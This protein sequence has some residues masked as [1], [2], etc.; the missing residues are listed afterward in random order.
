MEKIPEELT[1]GERYEVVYKIPG[2]HQFARYSIMDYLGWDEYT[3]S[4]WNAR[5]VAGTQSLQPEHII[6]I[7]PVSS[8]AP[9]KLNQ[10]WLG[11][12]D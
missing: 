11:K 8:M 10:R 7:Q 1:I 4:Q 9:I 12:E 3:G 6:Q 5:P 2:I